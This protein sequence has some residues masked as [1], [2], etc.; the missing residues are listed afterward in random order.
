MGTRA[1]LLL[2]AAAPLINSAA[3]R[4]APLEPEQVSIRS[5]LDDAEQPALFATPATAG[6]EDAK[7][8]PLLVS[9]HS[10]SADYRRYDS[11]AGALAACG[12]R[13][14]AFI[15]PDFR[16]PNRGPD[17]CA[18]DLAVQDVLDAVEYA[19][20]HTRID[21]RRIYLLGGSGGGHMAL[22]M[23]TRAPAVWAAVSAWVPITDLAEW[24]RFSSA[25]GSRYAL[26]IEACCGGPPGD[27]V[28]D[29][30]Y[31]R[32]SPL[33]HLADAVGV[34][35]DIQTGIHDG[36]H[37]SV[38]VTHSLRAFN[39]LA[40]AN[41]AADAQLTDAER[42]T[43]A[44]EAR[45][46]DHIASEPVD[47]PERT[48]PVL[49]RR[50]AGPVRLTL[51]DGGHVFDPGIDPARGPA[52]LW[53]AEQA[54]TEA[55]QFPAVRTGTAR[56]VSAHRIPDS[57]EPIELALDGDWAFC[58]TSPDSES[59]PRQ[60]APTA[61]DAAIRVPG[62]WDEQL[63]R[64]RHA[65]WLARATFRRSLGPVR[66]LYGIGWHRTRVM[67]ASDLGNRNVVLNVGWAV[68]VTHAW[69][70]E[71][72]VGSYEHGVYTPWDANV[73]GLLHAGENVITIA[74]DNTHG[75]TGGWASI[76]NAGRASGLTRPVTLRISSGNGRIDSVYVRPGED[77]GDA[78]W[79]VDLATGGPE[80]TC[81]ASVMQWEVL[82]TD[83]LRQL[84]H[85]RVPVPA[86]AG[87]RALTW[88]ARI[89]DIK[90]WSD[91]SPNLYRTVLGWQTGN[92]RRIDR[93]ERRFGLRRWSYKGRELYLNGTRIYLRGE[94]GAYYFPLHACAPADKD[95][96]MGHIRR[97]KEIGM[98]YINFAARVCPP[99]LLEAADE[100][101]MIMQCGD[102]MTVLEERRS[103]WREVWEP[104]VMWTRAHPSMCFYGFGGERDYY[105]GVL[106]QYAVQRDLIR[107]LHPESL[108]MP[109]QAIRGVDYAFDEAGRRE[110]TARPFPHHA[111]RLARYTEA[112]DLFGHYSGG[113]FGYNYFATRWQEMEERFAVYE[114]PLVAHE[115]YMGASY[116]NPANAARYTG[117]VPPYLYD[118]VR[119]KLRDAGLLE[120][121]PTYFENSARLHA[122]TKK[123]CVEKVRKCAGL[124]GYEFL[125]MTDMHFCEPEYAVGILDEFRQLKPGDTVPGI[126]RYNAESVLLLD[127]PGHPVNRS[128]RAGTPFVAQPMLSYFGANALSRGR[129]EWT[130]R[131]SGGRSLRDGHVDVPSV[132]RGSVFELDTIAFDWPAVEATTRTNLALTLTAPGVTLRNDWDFWI[133]PERDAPVVEASATPA[134]VE[135]LGRRYSTLRPYA[136]DAQPA[137]L[138][139][140][141]RLDA[142]LV[143]RLEQG[144]TVLLLGG[145]PFRQHTR[146]ASF[147]PGLGARPHHNVGTVIAQH[148]VFAHLPH[149]GWGDWQFY[150]LVEGAAAVLID[151]DMGTGFDPILEIVSSA[152][153]VRAQA[154]M[155][156]KQVGKGRLF[157]S[158]CTYDE[159]NPS[160]TALMDG[161]L[162]YMMTPATGPPGELPVS[163]L[164]DLLVPPP[165]PLPGNRVAN[166]GFETRRAL[167]SDWLAYG[168]PYTID[169]DT[170]HKGKRS[171]KVAITDDE[172]RRDPA[173]HT[174]AR[175]RNITFDRGEA[176]VTLGAWHRTQDVR[177]SKT[178]TDF[179]LFAYITYAN[180]SRYTLRCPLRGGTHEWEYTEVTW[181]PEHPV[182]SAVLYVGIIRN[183]GTAWVD[184][185]YLGQRPA[186]A[187]APDR[188]PPHEWHGEPV[189]LT[190]EKPVWFSINDAA[191]ERGPK[192]SVGTDGVNRV[193]LSR[194]T[195]R[196]VIEERTIAVDTHPPRIVLSAQPTL[197]QEG[198][199]Y[200]ATPE[201]SISITATDDASG[202]R[203]PE[204]SLD[205]TGFTAVAAPFHLGRGRHTLRCRALDRAGNVSTTMEGNELTGGATDL[206]TLIV[207]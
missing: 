38:P 68:G 20:N 67:A 178:P 165:S 123:Y 27:P 133:F 194:D 5:T 14:W 112:C 108:V 99:E 1:V 58:F 97:A 201:T 197:D 182:S 81:P 102:H 126:L 90:P 124:T 45:V 83:G 185:V 195:E 30:E 142:A 173:V 72:Y 203:P 48:C 198:G 176:E 188:E 103:E 132:V 54:R 186:D 16:G 163:V 49:F 8:V 13:G 24:H 169:A 18:S 17:A 28:R 15:S 159:T 111:G 71:T 120:R 200:Y 109:Q 34:P 89:P 11:Y 189:T 118:A 196:A 140:A 172:R 148:P 23:A 129:L 179:L 162:A 104:I 127:V 183:S 95:Y 168:T 167:K 21:D 91:R 93:R 52:F 73:T 40:R 145:F 10:W 44:D 37:G 57:P 47:E 63:E 154:A 65:A 128:F 138:L 131:D 187:R 157:V 32:R 156:E 84:A 42:M 139:V 190:F 192:L 74:I 56:E 66:Y 206:L 88:H 160:C 143:D 184:D 75:F 4:A 64:F 207:R 181:K 107:A 87:R 130:L 193:R 3:V 77:L 204:L 174:G 79:S 116:L 60:P 149:D 76:G 80:D 39:A 33:F 152:G 205:G 153:D 43:I 115:L 61:F 177:G 117:R 121:W 59:P 98:N 180:G 202:A 135:R 158:T 25:R 101:G 82:T 26:D 164:R 146:Y 46:P 85:G 119:G 29:L 199:V 137:P 69:V 122:I 161:L 155:F 2:M 55:P 144:G 151:E 62:A 170:A 175:A 9:L 100:L 86:F 35:I 113:A 191:W 106:E 141:E 70:N 171:L 150:P 147:R 12:Q 31:R 105:E 53:L 96:W 7:P 51:F 78:V 22:V 166:A 110:L 136:A 36:H 125:G 41:G 50:S 92:G 134:I 114:R 94:F 6:A 19:R